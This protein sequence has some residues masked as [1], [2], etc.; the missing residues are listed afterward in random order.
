MCIYVYNVNIYIY[1]SLYNQGSSSG[2]QTAV[3]PRRRERAFGILPFVLAV[4]PRSCAGLRH[5][6]LCPWLGRTWQWPFYILSSAGTDL[7]SSSVVLLLSK[8]V[9]VAG[10][11]EPLPMSKPRVHI[12]SMAPELRKATKIMSGSFER[13]APHCIVS[14]LL[15]LSRTNY[16]PYGIIWIFVSDLG[17][18]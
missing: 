14:D 1:I 17:R 13:S 2:A 9:L 4:A 10:L 6:S 11:T 7:Q 8:Q 5:S 15:S 18:R 3:A 16:Q 12:T